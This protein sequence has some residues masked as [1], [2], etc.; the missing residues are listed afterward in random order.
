MKSMPPRQLEPPNGRQGLTL[1]IRV[2]LR[3]LGAQLALLNLRVGDKLDLRAGDLQCLELIERLG[4]VSPASLARR[5]AIHPATLTGIIDRLER[6]GW[7]MRDRDPADRRSVVIRVVR[8][9]RAEVSR[10]YAGMQGRLTDI[11]AGLDEEE[12]AAV[13]GFLRSAVEAGRDATDELAG[14]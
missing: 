8:D 11:C 10:H 6:G 9:R 2:A 12:L 1:A 5:T 7:V 4:P 14:D 13:A 3:D